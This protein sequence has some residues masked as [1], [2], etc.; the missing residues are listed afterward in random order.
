MSEL[1]Y[2]S[3]CRPGIGLVHKCFMTSQSEVRLKLR[4]DEPDVDS[5][6]ASLSFSIWQA[7]DSSSPMRKITQDAYVMITG[8]LLRLFEHTLDLTSSDTMQLAQLTD[9]DSVY[10]FGWVATTI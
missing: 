8:A 3:L 10:D 2:L 1:T 5:S 9:V 7:E 4:L 6:L